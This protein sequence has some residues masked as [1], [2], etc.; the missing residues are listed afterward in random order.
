MVIFERIENEVLL[1]HINRVRITIYKK[2][3]TIMKGYAMMLNKEL[4]T[5]PWGI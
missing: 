1:D 4:L 2:E 3:D 5:S